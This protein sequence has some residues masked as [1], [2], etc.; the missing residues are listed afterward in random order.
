MEYTIA[1]K[2]FSFWRKDKTSTFSVTLSILRIFPAVVGCIWNILVLG[3]VSIIVAL[4]D[5]DE[6]EDLDTV[7]NTMSAALP[8]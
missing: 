1:Y 3:T 4:L 7:E 2:L 5:I 6:V 8:I